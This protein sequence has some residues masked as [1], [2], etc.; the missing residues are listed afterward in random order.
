MFYCSIASTHAIVLQHHVIVAME[1]RYGSS[2]HERSYPY[3]QVQCG[4][5]VS[6]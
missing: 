2:K 1:L 3:N 4:G 5:S 6:I